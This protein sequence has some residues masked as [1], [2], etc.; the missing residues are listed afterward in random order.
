ME[1][2]GSKT[3]PH[4]PSGSGAC[5]DYALEV[6]RLHAKNL[7]ASRARM[8]LKKPRSLPQGEP[9]GEQRWDGEGGNNT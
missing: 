9:G 5:F 3:S 6:T 7:E 4:R 8:G 1:D 2:D